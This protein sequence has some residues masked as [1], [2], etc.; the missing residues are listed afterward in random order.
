MEVCINIHS[1]FFLLFSLVHTSVKTHAILR[2]L[3]FNKGRHFPLF[4]FVIHNF[5][6]SLHFLGGE[7]PLTSCLDQFLYILLVHIFDYNELK[8]ILKYFLESVTHTIGA[9]Q[10]T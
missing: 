7:P 3:P 4:I 6:D 8:Y 2:I 9:R 10:V 5:P 1:L